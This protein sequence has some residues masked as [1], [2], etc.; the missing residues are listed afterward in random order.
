MRHIGFVMFRIRRRVFHDLVRRF[1]EE[2]LAEAIPVLYQ[3]ITTYNLNY[4]DRQGQPKPVRFVS[5]I[6][7]RIDGFILDF[8]QHEMENDRL[9]REDVTPDESAQ[10]A[11][12]D[13]A[14][15]DA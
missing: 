4:C 10:N 15:V 2:L 8:L 11:P 1:G 5:Y 12:W 7:K 3:K 13:Y 14:A 6:W 9:V